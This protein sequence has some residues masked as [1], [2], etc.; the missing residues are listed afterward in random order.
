[1]DP[2][3]E[4]H[5]VAFWE[6]DGRGGEAPGMGGPAGEVQEGGVRGGGGEVVGP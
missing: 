1:M 6:G 3:G 2:D 5:G 4:R